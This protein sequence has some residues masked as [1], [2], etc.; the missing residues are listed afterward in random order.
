ML[1]YIMCI[2]IMYRHNQTRGVAYKTAQA[3]NCCGFFTGKISL[4]ASLP[5]R[6]FGRQ[7]HK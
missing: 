5:P 3:L 2:W 7:N 4:F 6:S 1:D